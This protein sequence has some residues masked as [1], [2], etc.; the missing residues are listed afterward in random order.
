MSWLNAADPESSE[1]D[2]MRMPMVKLAW[3]SSVTK[4]TQQRASTNLTEDLGQV[5]IFKLCGPALK[6]KQLGLKLVIRIGTRY[7]GHGDAFD[8]FPTAGNLCGISSAKSIAIQ[9]H[10]GLTYL[11]E[12]DH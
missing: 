4:Q 11:G 9:F 3:R 10:R 5:I 8:R 12:G 7:D 6:G 2:V 1:S